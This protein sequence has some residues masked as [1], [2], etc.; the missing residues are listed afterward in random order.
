L[1]GE[2]Q[3]NTVI[4]ESE[5]KNIHGLPY[6]FAIDSCIQTIMASFNSWN[7]S[8]LHG[9]KYLLTDVL[10]DKMQFDGLIVGDWNGHGQ[11][12]ECTNSDCAASFNA[13]VDIFMAP[14]EWKGL[15][16]N[17]LNQVKNGSI[18]EER[19][20]DAIR[21]ILRV[22]NILGLF[23]GR[24]PHIFNENFIG[25]DKHRE[26]ARRSV[27][28]SIVLLKNNDDVLPLNPKKTLLSC[29]A[30]IQRY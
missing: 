30:G 7:G 2:D 11:L 18:K 12:P 28:E 23:D 10:K 22:K 21:R 6:Y 29:W 17:T 25:S 8:K 24:K 3:G 1:N 20:D 15:Y 13:G 26:I 19:L 16:V 27:R 5:L 9:S 14:D 4:S